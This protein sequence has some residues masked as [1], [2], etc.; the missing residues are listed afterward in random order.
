MTASGVQDTIPGPEHSLEELIL[1]T[2]RLY[3][4]PEVSACE[5]TSVPIEAGLSGAAVLRHRVTFQSPRGGPSAVSLITKN[6]TLIERRVLAL[7]QAQGQPCVPFSH[8][9][10]LTD[11]TAALVCMQDLGSHHR[12]TSLE[13]IE[14][15]LVR[16]EAEGLALI[17]QAN[18][19]KVHEL[20][21]LP[22]VDRQY[23]HARISQYW[24]PAWERAL[25]RPAFRQEFGRSIAAVE[26]VA[27]GVADEIQHLAEDREQLSLLHG[28]IN[29]SNVLIADERP[30]LIDWQAACY[31]PF[32]LDLPHHLHTVALAEEYRRARVAL[33]AEISYADFAAGFRAAA[34]FI[35]LR[36]IWW[37][38]DLWQEDPTQAHWIRYYLD[39]ITR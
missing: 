7:L 4:A 12:P 26:A 39:L 23:V 6:A 1:D 24:E 33:G 22:R 27:A 10:N 35:G 18:A 25:A 3:V 17:H 31:G 13:S 30:W 34:H 14:P 28:D 9:V 32:Y 38:L 11:D 37:T 5:I 8:S 36:C 16:Q 20:A 2:V 19:G 21:W 15:E 29:P